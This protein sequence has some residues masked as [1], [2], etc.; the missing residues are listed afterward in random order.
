ML[1]VESPA[2]LTAG[3]G[4]SVEVL[5]R[6]LL[7]RMRVR[8]IAGDVYLKADGDVSDALQDGSMD[9]VRR[10]DGWLELLDQAL[11]KVRE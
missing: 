8:H 6:G 9:L 7:F 3:D 1:K 5:F 10:S 11:G 4:D 2:T